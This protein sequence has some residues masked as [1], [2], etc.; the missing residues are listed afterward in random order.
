MTNNTTTNETT[1]NTAL[2]TATDGLLDKV[3]DILTATPELL[4]LGAVIAALAAYIAYTQPAVRA[5]IMPYI[6]NYDDEI[7]SILDKGLTKAQL[8]AYVKLDEVAQKHVKDAV[9]RNV[10]L[11]TWDQNDDKFVAIVKTEAKVA[12]A[13]AKKL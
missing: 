11:S 3:V 4:F 7:L 10:V 8:A 2:D 6:K 9:L 1:N 13:E 12:L 5:L